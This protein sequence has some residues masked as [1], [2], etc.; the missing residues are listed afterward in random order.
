MKGGL[1]PLQAAIVAF[2]CQ[3]GENH[4]YIVHAILREKEGVVVQQS[5]TIKLAL[6]NS[7]SQ[8][9]FSSLQLLHKIIRSLIVIFI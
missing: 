2:H 1:S 3:N 9:P 5:D 6:Q 4:E 8:M 7:I